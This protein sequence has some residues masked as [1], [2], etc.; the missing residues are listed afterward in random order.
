MCSKKKL[1]DRL[2]V[3]VAVLTISGMG[4]GLISLYFSTGQYGAPLYSFYMSQ[5]L[6]VVLNLLPFVLFNYLFYVI[7]NRVWVAFAVDSF[8]CFLFSWPNYWKLLA[9]DSPLMAS[10]LLIVSEAL[11]MS[12]RYVNFT[13]LMIGTLLGALFLTVLLAVF[14]RG[15]IST[16]KSRIV[17]FLALV[18]VCVLLLGVY[19]SPSLF[20]AQPVW[21]ELT[22]WF[23]TSQMIS[24]GG[25]YPFINTIPYMFPQSPSGYTEGETK[26]A[27]ASYQTDNIPQ[28]RQA[29]VIVVMLEAFADFSELTDAITMDDPYAEYHALQAESYCGTLVSNAFAG[30]TYDTEQSVVSGFP[31][32]SL[33]TVPSWSYVRYF[34]AQ[35]YAINGAHAGYRGFYNR[36]T[37]NANLGFSDYRFID[38]YYSLLPEGTLASWDLV[39]EGTAYYL[40][41]LYSNTTPMDFQ[42]LPEITDFCKKQIEAGQPVFSFNVTYQNHGPYPTNKAL[43]PKEY[44][45]I[46][47]MSEADYNIANNYFAGVAETAKRMNEMVDAFRDYEEPVVLVFFGD[48]MPWMGDQ[49]TTYHALGVDIS[50]GTDS[51]FL[52]YFSTDYLIWANDAAKDT[53]DNRFVG[54]GPTISPAFLMNVVFE[55]CG[56]EGPGY[57]KL[58]DEVMS[59]FPVIHGT[60]VYSNGSS[61]ITDSDLTVEQQSLLD[62]LEYICFYLTNKYMME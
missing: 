35:G 24:R 32:L 58:T 15:Y 5:G 11:D 44:V 62:K 36:G 47:N 4:L 54:T 27:L 9:R 38:N 6:I 57:Q 10:D 23:V 26:A 50:S 25:I 20:L 42:L 53:L 21:P 28:G 43:F 56:W 60:G 19:F 46:G 39:D 31:Y 14:F 30:G 37:V 29:S 17:S 12:K 49:N 52:N 40:T 41:N 2:S 3:T 45:P 18:L 55:Q 33:F 59:V 8:L 7:T 51:S 16:K 1:C 48:H 61:L 13:P 22:E 34:D